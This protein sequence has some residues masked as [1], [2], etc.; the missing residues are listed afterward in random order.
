MSQGEDIRSLLDQGLT[1]YGLGEDRRALDTW[2]KVLEAEPGNPRAVEYIRFVEENWAPNQDRDDG[3][4]RPDEESN[5]AGKTI[6]QVDSTPESG[7]DDSYFSSPPTSELEA[8]VNPE[9]GEQ[10]AGQARA[11]PQWGRR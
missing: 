7:V 3:S 10:E 5:P 4:Y 2:K 8:P 6:E 1:Y 11:P 9:A